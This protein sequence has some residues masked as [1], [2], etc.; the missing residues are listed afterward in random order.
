MH[1]F[2]A[3]RIYLIG[4][5]A[6]GKSSLGA[7][8][9]SQLDYLYFDTDEA[10]EQLA[11]QTIAEMFNEQGEDHFRELEK[12][13]AAFL[14]EIDRVVVSTGGG[15]PIYNG[16]MSE[17]LETGITIY[18]EC[19]PEVLT[20]RLLA[21]SD[22]RPLHAGAQGASHLHI[23]I[24]KKLEER[25]LIYRQAHLVVQADKPLD[26]VAKEIISKL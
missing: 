20:K 1:S 24:E 13:Q 11:N 2:S 10:I 4:Y 19:S 8:L 6:S 12:Q 25:N 18:L 7:L 3:D 5:M 26:Q 23:E 15:L 9:A 22:H 21:D 17:L 14:K 16:L